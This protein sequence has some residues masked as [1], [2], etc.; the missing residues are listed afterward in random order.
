MQI[1]KYI[2][3]FRFHLLYQHVS[4]HAIYV[5]FITTLIFVTLIQLESIFYFDPR[6]KESILMIL[7]GFFILTL[8]G[9]LVY[10]HQAKNDNIKRYSIEKLASVLGKDIFSDKRDIVLNALQ[11]ETSSG[12][13]ESRALAQ[14]YINSVKK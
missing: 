3:K 12:E 11:L 5:V 10:Y 2:K 7:V 13:N 14:S 6:T 8:I 4:A 1:E 9:W